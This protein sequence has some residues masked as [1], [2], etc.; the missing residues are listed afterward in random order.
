[1]M[2]AL[3]ADLN[4]VKRPSVQSRFEDMEIVSPVSAC[5]R[6][7]RAPSRSYLIG[8]NVIECRFAEVCF[9]VVQ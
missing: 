5:V 6:C 2:L 9:E 4:L 7:S 8:K 1:M 3:I